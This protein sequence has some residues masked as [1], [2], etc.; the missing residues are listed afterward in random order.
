MQFTKR[1]I[2][3]AAISLTGTASFAQTVNDIINKNIEAMG[4]KDKLSKLLSVY[5]ENTTSVMGN[6]LN[7]KVWVVNGQGMR[8][9]VEVMGSTIITVMTKDTGWMVNPMTGNTDPQP[10]PM[11]QVK[12]SASRMDLR[13]QFL[14]Y[15]ANGY[16]ATLVGKE[17]VDGK[18]NYKVKLSKTGEGDL[19]FYVDAATY[20]VNKMVTTTKA[21]GADVTAE[22][23]FADYKKTPE[24]YIFPY[25]TTISNA[26]TGE[27]KSTITKVVP[28]QAVDP[29]LFQKP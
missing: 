12:Q 15:A 7:S 21:N 5:E 4:G 9:E 3:A 20:Y 17:Q 27:I 23:A 10:I 22:I 29:K 14:D 11:E 25:T 8:A 26:Q 18:D 13:G 6:D 1:I 24:G 2:L 28:N 19:L 16:N